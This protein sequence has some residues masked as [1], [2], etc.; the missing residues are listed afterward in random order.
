M[1][2]LSKIVADLAQIP[3]PRCSPIV[4]A[5]IPT[6]GKE[7]SDQIHQLQMRLIQMA[8]QLNLP[9]IAMVA[10]GPRQSYRHR[11]S[12]TRKSHRILL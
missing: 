4:V 6:A 3:L 2:S 9:I 11:A 12:W 8:A 1:P 7:T 5:L 10:D